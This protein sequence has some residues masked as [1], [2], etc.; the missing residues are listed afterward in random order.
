MA[1]KQKR[2][3]DVTLSTSSKE[4]RKAD[5][6][7]NEPR[8]SARLATR[9]PLASL[10]SNLSAFDLSNYRMNAAERLEDE[11]DETYEPPVFQKPATEW[12]WQRRVSSP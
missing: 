8:K 5:A 10:Q 4:K 7:V 2:D 1:P 12:A 3:A 9:E 11:E 6:P